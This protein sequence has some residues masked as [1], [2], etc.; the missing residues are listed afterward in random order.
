MNIEG[1]RTWYL[2]DSWKVPEIVQSESLGLGTGWNLKMDEGFSAGM[3][4]SR[5]VADSQLDGGS[6]EVTCQA[7]LLLVGSV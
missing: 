6:L 1:P 4:Q 5:R 2:S 3:T 7:A